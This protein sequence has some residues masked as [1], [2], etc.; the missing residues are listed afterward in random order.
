MHLPNLSFCIR[1]KN[2]FYYPWSSVSQ[3]VQKGTDA[4]MLPHQEMVLVRVQGQVPVAVFT[5]LKS[6]TSWRSGMK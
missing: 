3:Q 4:L 2:C 1:D 6:S 5:D